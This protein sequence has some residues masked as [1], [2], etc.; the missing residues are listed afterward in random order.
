M[1]TIVIATDG[2]EPAHE[3]VELGVELAAPLHAEVVFVHVLAK[4]DWSPGSYGNPKRPISERDRQALDEAVA[5]AEAAG[6]DARVEL[7][8]GERGA[9]DE[10]VTCADTLDAD[11]IVVGS[12]GRGALKST[13]LGRV[14]REV[15]H[16]ARRPVLVAR[17]VSRRRLAGSEEA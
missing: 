13:V 17:A 6:V 2:S 1:K 12:R 8:I 10:I 15:L 14:S 3:A 9:G 7:V 5:F 11:L 4:P 16:E